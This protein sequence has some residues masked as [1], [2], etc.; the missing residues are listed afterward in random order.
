MY[1]WKKPTSSWRPFMIAPTSTPSI[2]ART[3]T[4]GIKARSMRCPTIMYSRT[5]GRSRSRG[6][7]TSPLIR[8]TYAIAAPVGQRPPSS[9]GSFGASSYHSPFTEACESSDHPAV[10]EQVATADETGFVGEQ[11]PNDGRDLFGTTLAPERCAVDERGHE[12]VRGC[13]LTALRRV[14]DPRRHGA[15]ASTVA[16]P[17]N[18]LPAHQPMHAAL[19]PWVRHCRI[20]DRRAR[21]P[22]KLVQEI[23]PEWLVDHGVDRR[24]TVGHR[25]QRR[26]RCEAHRRGT[27]G[28]ERRERVDQ[29]SRANEVDAEDALPFRHR[30]RDPSSVRNH[31]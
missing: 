23:R 27:G 31:A 2:P 28:D 4:C 24:V 30:R 1:W 21:D 18:G 22:A 7:S 16:A 15:D 19:G 26:H 13:L 6:K 14:D 11:E 20:F 5:T 8:I 12:R 3:A 17:A 9:D 25:Q 29:H 10:H